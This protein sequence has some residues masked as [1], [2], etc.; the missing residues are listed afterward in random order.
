MKVLIACDGSEQ[1]E[2]ALR[3]ATKLPLENPTFFP[4]SIVPLVEIN[5]TLVREDAR[6]EI[7]AFN[8]KLEKQGRSALEQATKILKE[9]GHQTNA[10]FIRGDAINKLLEMS[11]RFDLLVMGSRGLNPVQSFFLGS[12]SDALIRGSACPVF[13]YRKGKNYDPPADKC[14]I[15]FGYGNNDSSDKAFAFLK[16]LD[17]KKVETVDLVSVMQMNYYYGMSYSLA[18][19]EAWPEHKATLEESLFNLQKQLLEESKGTKVQT[20][21]ITDSYDIANTLNIRAKEQ[22]SNL[23]VTGCESKN[24]MD[25]MVL[26]STSNKLAHHAD[27]PVLIIR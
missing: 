17:L 23:I 11:S 13:L 10:E 9:A 24:F 16:K 3:F 14:R 21:I 20:D 8:E 4:V 2:Q 6:A 18:A 26:G 19:L 1:S 5:P 25:R 27:M 22:K 7:D 15:T 12:V